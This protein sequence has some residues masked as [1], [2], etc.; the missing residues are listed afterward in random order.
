MSKDAHETTGH[1]K[2]VPPRVRPK[3]AIPGWVACKVEAWAWVSRC[4]APLSSN[5][6]GGG[7]ELG[8]FST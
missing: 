3:D 4:A 6:S 2:K 1:Y 5:D 7:M 8:S